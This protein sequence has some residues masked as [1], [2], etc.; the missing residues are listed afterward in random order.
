MEVRNVRGLDC[1]AFVHSRLDAVPRALPRLRQRTLLL[2]DE[3]G[4]ALRRMHGDPLAVA[5]V[6]PRV[7]AH[8]RTVDSLVRLSVEGF[9]RGRLRQIYLAVHILILN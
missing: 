8:I 4:R 7:L 9:G 5:A 6:L 2:G 3:L 1:V